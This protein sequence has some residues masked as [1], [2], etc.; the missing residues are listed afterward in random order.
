MGLLYASIRVRD[1]KKSVAFYTKN[2]GMKV[3]ERKSYMPG[4]QVITLY[5]ADTKQHMRMMYYS[6]SCE[7]YAPY[8]LDGVELDHLTFEVP[9]AKKLY[10]RLV[11]AGAPAATKLWER[12]GTAMGFV[13]DPDKI[14]VGMVSHSKKK[15]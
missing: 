5:S 11:K 15:K 9:D 2:F 7:L 4:E 6:K 8:K 12:D 3:T 14:W 1:P 13:K 10:N